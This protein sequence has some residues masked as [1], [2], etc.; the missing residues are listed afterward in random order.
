MFP[1]EEKFSKQHPLNSK[2]NDTDLFVHGT[3]KNNYLSI[4]SEGFMKRT[5]VVRNY[6]ISIEGICFEKYYEYGLKFHVVDMT[7]KG[8][9]SAAC[10]MDGSSESIVL[11]ITGKKLKGLGCNIYAGWNKHVPRL[12]NAVGIP[13]DVDSDAL[14]SIIILDCDI[15]FKYLKIMKKV[16][17]DK[18]NL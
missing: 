9:C 10:K 11:Q 6:S 14:L 7:I 4:K 3:S 2:I 13:F 15:P 12:Y 16:P 1:E 18:L 17:S 5:G 8:H